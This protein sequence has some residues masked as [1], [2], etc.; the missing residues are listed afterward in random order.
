MDTNNNKL[1]QSG[2][3]QASD[4]AQR[5]GL[6]AF[7]ICF[8]G[9]QISF[10]LWGLMQERIVKYTY[11]LTQN[12]SASE[13][14]R[15]QRFKNSQFLVLT[16]RFAGLLLSIAILLV[17]N[18][19]RSLK[20]KLQAYKKL[21]SYSNWP[22]L[23]ICSYSSL[24]NVLSSW[25]QYESLK[26]VTFTS[27]LLAKSS[28]SIFVMLT[29]KVVSNKTYKA[30][31]YFCVG[32][33]GNLLDSISNVSLTYVIGVG[34]FLFSDINNNDIHKTNRILMTTLPGFMC[35]F[36]YLV[37]D[38]FTSTWQDNLIKSYSISSISLMFI[39]NFYSC[40][41]TFVCLILEDQWSE[42]M[43]FLNQHQDIT[44][45]IVL[46][47]ITSAIGQI[48]I[49]VTIQ[50]FGALVFSLIMTTRQVL[51]IVL[52]SIVF[53]HSMSAQSVFGIFI[54]FLA[55]FL[56]QYLKFNPGVLSRFQSTNRS[57]SSSRTARDNFVA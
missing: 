14:K 32:L 30:H 40:L 39:T 24:S 55:L 56:Q 12:M 28:K 19:H 25:F 33:I 38:S 2:G 47:S 44:Q 46:L 29:A 43:D 17:T 9:L 7:I 8:L 21:F 4:G 37:S 54:I 49:F 20:L 31:E 36:G 1:S 18:R 22:P 26:Y 45:H 15:A 53:Q 13:A 16:N 52:S 57:R 11:G 10:L 6:L 5:P 3:Q 42:T 50:K 41:Y 34:I 35:L 48:F 27:Q 51:S 23:F